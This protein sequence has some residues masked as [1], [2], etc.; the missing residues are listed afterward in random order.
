MSERNDGKDKVFEAAICRALGRHFSAEVHLTSLRR[1][2]GGASQETYCLEALVGQQTRKFALR[3]APGGTSVL[4]EA[5]PGLMTEA[6]IMQVARKAQVPEPDIVYVLRP[7]DGLGDG[8]IMD[9]LSGETLGAR[10]NKI[11]ELDGI[12]PELARD[13]GRILA[14]IH[15]IDLDASGLRANLQEVSTPGFVHQV[16]DR[17]KSSGLPVPMIDFIARWLLENLPPDQDPRLV[18]NDFRNGNLMVTPNGINA[19]LDW[20]LAHIGDPVRDIGWICTN[21]WRFGQTE[22]VVGGFGKLDDLLDGYEQ[23][24]GRRISTQHVT[25]WEVFGSFWWAVNCIAIYEPYRN[26]TDPSVERP[27]VARRSSEAQVDCCNLIIPG[28]LNDTAP[29]GAQSSVDLPDVQ[30]LLSSVATFLRD[31]LRQELEG[32]HKFMSLVAAN[33][34]GIVERELTH[35]AAFRSAEQAGLAKVLG[36]QGSLG[37]LRQVLADALQSGEMP[38]S[39]PG[40]ATHLRNTAVN[41]LMIDQPTYS[42]L[43]NARKLADPKR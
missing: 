23:E 13:C 33:S 36:Q 30:T 32:R 34:L 14:R 28:P 27:V 40:L 35:A 20:E 5:G 9:W 3:R 29:L 21:S 2:S 22:N 16:W 11:P 37:T 7:E 4:G 24:S 42:G 41:Q 38:L 43:S 25:F 15:N 1:L 39:T 17:H 26:G 8:F 19:V 31:D 6:R 12:R 10:I 18:H